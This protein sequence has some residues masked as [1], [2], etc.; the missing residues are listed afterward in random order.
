VL[1]RLSDPNLLA[2]ETTIS[3]GA[4]ISE[5]SGLTWL[6]VDLQDGVIHIVQRNRRGFGLAFY[7]T[8]R[9]KLRSKP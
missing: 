3:T 4:R 6:H 9:Y 1:A 5:I 2:I 7:T 8:G